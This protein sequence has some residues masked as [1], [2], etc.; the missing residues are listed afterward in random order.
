[1]TTIEPKHEYNAVQTVKRRFF[2]MR[3]GII[4]DVLRKS[5]SGFKIIFGLNLPQIAEIADESPHTAEF[6][7]TLWHN[8]TTRESMLIA[9]MLYPRDEFDEATARIW[10]SEVPEVEVADILCHRLLRFQP[11]ALALAKEYIEKGNSSELE[12][13]TALR[14]AFNIVNKYPDEALALASHPDNGKFRHTAGIAR[15]LADE[16]RFISG[17]GDPADY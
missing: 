5:G 1:M 11:Y 15:S 8:T 12:R 16:A 10:I 17:N 4:G 9:P 7:T 2:A 6:A 3:N 14:L 13:Y